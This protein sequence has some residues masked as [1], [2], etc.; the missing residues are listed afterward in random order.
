MRAAQLEGL[1]LAE[2]LRDALPRME[3][4][5]N[6]GGGSM[7]A[8]FKRADRSGA[9]VALVLGDDELKADEVVMKPLRSGADQQRV[10]TS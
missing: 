9:A 2:T 4:V 1:I 5:C 7:K 3:I 6:C 8:Q 10:S